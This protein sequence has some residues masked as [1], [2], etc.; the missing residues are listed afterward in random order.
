M[1]DRNDLG[2][3]ERV[4]ALERDVAQGRIERA[5]LEHQVSD[6]V[7]ALNH[8]TIRWQAAIDW[9]DKLR[10]DD[11]ESLALRFERIERRL[12]TIMRGVAVA[13][14]IATAMVVEWAREW[15]REIWALFGGG[16]K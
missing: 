8:L 7:T 11:K 12:R 6:L 1:T 16:V 2:M 10:T 5:E 9:V 4:N 15:A 14:M 13:G 3:R